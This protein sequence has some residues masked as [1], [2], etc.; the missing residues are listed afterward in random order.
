M[1]NI[2]VLD[3]TL[4]DGG[5]IIN[6]NFSDSQ[7]SR[8]TYLLQEANIDIIEVGFLRDW[9]NTEYNGNTTFFTNTKQIEPFLPSERKAMYVAFVDFGMFDF[10]SLD[11]YNGKSIDGIRF[12]FTKR[13][14]LDSKEEVIKC[15]KEI[16]GKGYK[17]FLQGVN[18]L[19]YSDLEFLELIKIVNEIEPYSFGIVDTYGAMYSDDIQRLYAL[20]DNNLKPNIAIDFHSHNNFQLSFSFAQEIIKLSNG[21][22]NVIIDATLRGMGKGAGNTNIELVVDYLVRKKKCNYDL[23][24]VLE[25]IDLELYDIYISKQWGYSP[26]TLMAGIYKSHPNNITYLLEKYRFS[27]NDIKNIL[28]KLRNTERERYPYEKIDYLVEEY[29]YHDYNDSESL[30][31]LRNMI[32][33]RKVLVLAPG[34]SLLDNKKEIELFINENNPWI[35]S[36]NFVA[37]YDNSIPFFGNKKRYYTYCYACE[38]NVIVTS[39]IASN[40]LNEIIVS[41]KRVCK[42]EKRNSYSS[43][44]KLLNLLNNLKV[45]EIF[46]AG[47]DGVKEDCKDNY[48]DNSLNVER[49]REDYQ[50]TNARWQQDFNEFIENKYED[51]HIGFITPTFLTFN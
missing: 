29:C 38:N 51:C 37:E 47:M 42:Y 14:L 21:V 3:C 11:K 28:S 48:F 22:R 12:G 45:K 36:V 43:L 27:T 1:N 49:T 26:A 34:K 18:S 8:I 10:E 5:R 50:V 30:T 19:N 4:R 15:A 2:S 32:D 25:I 7:I 33:K 6:C 16:K 31:K 35:I 39:D 40:N 9:R 13:N 44:F 24:K 20:T 41:A 46:I 17:L 23:E